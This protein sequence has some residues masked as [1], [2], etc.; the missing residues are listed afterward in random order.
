MASWP[1]KQSSTF[2][3]PLLGCERPIVLEAAQSPVNRNSPARRTSLRHSVAV[4]AGLLPHQTTSPV[5]RFEHPCLLAAA[6][7][8]ARC[9]SVFGLFLGGLRIVFEP[10][11]GASFCAP[12]AGHLLLVHSS[13]LSHDRVRAD[14]VKYCVAQGRD[15]PLHPVPCAARLP[16]S[17]FQAIEGKNTVC[18]GVVVVSLSLFKVTRS[19]EAPASNK[20]S[21]ILEVL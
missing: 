20:K 12:A 14:L 15:L 13:A 11:D 1:L 9:L 7:F 2:S 6:F 5:L 8:P 4:Q 10:C 21:S 16:F 3:L 18:T 17:F 19:F